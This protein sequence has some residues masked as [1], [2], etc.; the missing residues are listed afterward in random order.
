MPTPNE[1]AANVARAA[2]LARNGNLRKAFAVLQGHPE[3]TSQGDDRQLDTGPGDD[4]GPA[5]GDTGPGYPAPDYPPVP[6]PDPSY[7]D[8]ED[9]YPYVPPVG[10]QPMTAPP[11]APVAVPPP[12]PQAGWYRDP[13]DNQGFRYWNGLGW[14]SQT[15]L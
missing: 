14:T 6:Y 8:V 13:F 9:Y 7:P 15:F 1:A 10:Q 12:S 3:Q 11:D 4:R 2:E 5:I